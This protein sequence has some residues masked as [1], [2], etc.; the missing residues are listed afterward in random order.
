MA[1]ATLQ[2]REQVLTAAELLFA[3]RGFAATSVADIEDALGTQAGSLYSLIDTKEDLLW[4]IVDSAATR[5]TNAAKP[6]IESDLPPV[7]KLSRV[8]A[9]HV[10]ENT[11]GAASASVYSTQWRHL[12][13]PRRSEFLARRRAYVKLLRG[14]VRDCIQDGTFGNID[15]KFATLLILSS[16]NWIYQ[17]Y[18][19]DGPMTPED[20]AQ[21]LTS[22]LFDGLCGAGR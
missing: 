19:P 5:Y 3:R 9:A 7:E 20:I 21:K 22:L 13:E 11:T 15:E 6:I 18:R 8:I 16:M 14:L 2:R 10:R 4:E 12:A 1:E 17:W